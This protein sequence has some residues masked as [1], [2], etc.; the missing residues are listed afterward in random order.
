MFLSTPLFRQRLVPATI[1]VLAIILAWSDSFAVPFIFDDITN[2]VR[3]DLVRGFWHG[4]V[5]DGRYTS[6]LHLSHLR[7]VGLFSFRLNYALGG[8]NTFGYHVTN[9]CI[10][11][12]NALLAWAVTE[13]ALRSHA[14]ALV[15]WRRATLL[16]WTVAA[17]WALHPLQTE[18]VTYI[19]QRLES[20]MALFYLATLFCWAK[21]VD[22]NSPAWFV[23]AA[24]MCA[25]GMG[26]KEVM[27]TAP[28][29][30]FLYDGIFLSRSWREALRRWPWYAALL[31][32]AAILLFRHVVVMD[33]ML[34]SLQPDGDGERFS[35]LA[36]EPRALVHY[37]RL[38]V[39]P[40]PLTFDHDWEPSIGYREI[41]PYAA[42]IAL[43]LGYSA[44]AL[45]RRKPIGFALSAFFI[46]LSPSSSVIPLMRD[47]VVEHRVYLPTL[48]VIAV[49]VLA[50]FL[51]GWR[52]LPSQDGFRST[53]LGVALA[54]LLTCLGS[55]T[56]L[57][58]LDYRDEA[59]LWLDTAA[60]A[61]N[62]SRT[63][64]NLG[65]SLSRAGRAEEAEQAFIKSL[66][67]N[68][69]FPNPYFELARLY[70]EKGNLELAE[71]V[72]D[73]AVRLFP[74]EADLHFQRGILLS[75]LGRRDD[76]EAEYRACLDVKPDHVQAL[77]NLGALLASKG[78]LTGA[79]QYYT[80][81]LRHSPQNAFAL[82]NLASV[83]ERQLDY[84]GAA[85]EYRKAVLAD[86]G[87]VEARAGLAR[88][89]GMLGDLEGA[90]A[91]IADALSLDP[92]NP[93]ARSV[94]DALN[95]P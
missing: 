55:L 42:T 75:K 48:P 36:T 12:I 28:L 33:A 70:Q 72:T 53:A 90:R 76:A 56:Y 24:A 65:V 3:N 68:P 77:V 86:P 22:R 20:M 49:L 25:L 73:K 15:F 44:W 80:D 18:A 45:A 1:L 83:L 89:L 67:L 61:P 29:T 59:T 41:V 27:I 78:D 50:A 35:Y 81:A 46:I 34:R 51:A 93:V 54:L 32:P 4:E 58:N 85:S 63:Q 40:Y 62:N 95:G 9:T 17:I 14:M 31:L 23:L 91:A 30:V 43:I 74:G 19:V 5:A 87:D 8:F 84:A 71:R 88:A 47:Y 39:W 52:I 64:H 66:E 11:I 16:A 21:A 26:T 13:R 92:D 38:I 57:R 7:P 94:Y 37:L 10:H 60:K 6:A 82:F 69:M 2:I 79:S